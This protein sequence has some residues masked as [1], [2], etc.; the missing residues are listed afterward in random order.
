M[1]SV[2]IPAELRE[3]L[4]K[5][6]RIKGSSISNE[7]ARLIDLQLH[8]ELPI[9]MQSE[10]SAMRASAYR[11]QLE[12]LETLILK[13]ARPTSTQDATARLASLSRSVKEL[14]TRRVDLQK[15]L[16][17]DVK[18]R[19]ALQAVAQPASVGGPF[20]GLDRSIVVKDT[21]LKP[22]VRRWANLRSELAGRPRGIKKRLAQELGWTPSQI[23]QLLSRP[24]DRNH[25]NITPPIARKLERVL[26]LETG[27][28]DRINQKLSLP[29][30]IEAALNL[31]S[32]LACLNKRC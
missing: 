19:V 7:V 13:M 15:Q 10:L 5:A 29:E 27:A 16:E 6:A 14:R 2:R 11:N 24:N 12:S 28:L 8:A 31:E 3:K 21:Q 25:R 18:G 20:G 30:L 32:T 26:G 22:A 17:A 9:Y 23:S 1:L 4:A